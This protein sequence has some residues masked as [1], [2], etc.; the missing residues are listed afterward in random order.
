MPMI[1]AYVPKVQ[2]LVAKWPKMSIFL[3]FSNP[4]YG[5]NYVIILIAYVPKVY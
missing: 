3:R 4:L 2:K 1:F 5:V